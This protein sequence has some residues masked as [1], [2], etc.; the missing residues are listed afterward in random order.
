MD[1]LKKN[2]DLRDPINWF[3]QARSL[4]RRII[5]HAGPTNSGKT[6]SALEALKNANSGIYCGPLKLLAVEVAEKINSIDK[7]CD[8]ITGDDK[9]YINEDLSAS[10]HMAC[11]IEMANMTKEFDVAVIDEIQLI[12]DSDRGWVRTF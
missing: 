12:S 1:D 3:P 10:S 4:Q 2:S 5:Y 11:T 8:L 7:K 9:S 6:Y